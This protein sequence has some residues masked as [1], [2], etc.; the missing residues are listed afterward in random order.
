MVYSG[1]L[2]PVSI[3]VT[4]SVVFHSDRNPL[5]FG[6]QVQRKASHCFSLSIFISNGFEIS[7]SLYSLSK[8][9]GLNVGCFSSPFQIRLITLRLDQKL[10]L[11][12]LSQRAELSAAPLLPVRSC[13]RHE[14]SPPLLCSALST[15]RDLSCSSHTLLYR[16]FIIFVVLLWMLT[17]SFVSFLYCGTQ[18]CMQYSR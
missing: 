10:I 15:P 17:N 18:N 4:A 9:E 6:L 14:A 3:L 2:L 11:L 5:F 13:R 12:S 1:F 8:S 16:T 7:S